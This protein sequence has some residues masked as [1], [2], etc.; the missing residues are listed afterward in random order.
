[1]AE[2]VLVYPETELDPDPEVRSFGLI[3]PLS[4]IYAA[5]LT[6]K[7]GRSV[8]I[9]DQRTDIHWRDSLK[10]AAREADCRMV[11]ISSMTGPQLGWGLRASEVVRSANPDLP[12][13]W[14]GVHPTLRPEETLRNPLIDICVL[15]E[16]ELVLADLVDA[17]AQGVPLGEVEGIAY[18]DPGNGEIV[19]RERVSFIDLNDVG[20]PPYHLVDHSLYTHTPFRRGERSIAVLTSR[21]CPFRCGYCYSV[22]FDNRR[23]RALTPE[24]TLALFKHI[25]ETYN[26]RSMVMLDDMFT[27]DPKRVRRICE[28]L[29]EADMGL[30]IHNANIRIDSVCRLDEDVLAMMKQVGFTKVFIGAESG[31]DETL[32]LI[33]K[34]SRQK[35]LIEGNRRLA[36]AGIQPVYN[37]MAGFPGETTEQSKLTLKTMVQM[38]DDNPEMLTYG[39]SLFSPFPGTALFDL[40]IKQGMKTPTRLEDWTTFQYNELQYIDFPEVDKKWFLRLVRVAPFF[41]FDY[42]YDGEPGFRALAKRTL[43]KLL[44]FRIRHDLWNY[45]VEFWLFEKV[46]VLRARLQGRVA[47]RA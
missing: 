28:L 21:G 24:N 34:D 9:I 10:N 42:I 32:K 5:A 30:S 41:S 19:V 4:C 18:R 46:R 1:M 39:F 13:V 17:L 27:V 16:G 2:V 35:H 45:W 29:I 31:T 6:V 22:V 25:V 38:H 15:G 14:G 40:S 20:I 33:Q 3:A 7:R 37:F 12:I 26:T 36:A 23:W 43:A 47:P 8:Q 44:R 11:G